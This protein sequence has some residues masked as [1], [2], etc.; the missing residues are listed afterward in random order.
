MNARKVITIMSIVSAR[1]LDRRTFMKL[2]GLSLCVG[3][4]FVAFGLRA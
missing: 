1:T 2:A 3:G 4:F